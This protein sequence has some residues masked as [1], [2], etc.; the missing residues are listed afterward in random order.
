LE[1]FD[2]HLIS[3]KITVSANWLHSTEKGASQLS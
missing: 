2:Q 3:Y 1:T